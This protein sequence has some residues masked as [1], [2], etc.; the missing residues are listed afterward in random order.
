[1]TS[2]LL[3][4]VMIERWS[5]TQTRPNYDLKLLKFKPVPVTI[6]HT[7]FCNQ[8]WT[9]LWNQAPWLPSYVG[10]KTWNPCI[11]HS[12]NWLQQTMGYHKTEKC[13]CEWRRHFTVIHDENKIGSRICRASYRT[14]VVI[15]RIQKIVCKVILGPRY[16]HY[17][18]ACL[19]LSVST[20][21]ARRKHL[22]LRFALA[23]LTSTSSKK[24]P[25]LTISSETSNHLKYLFAT[26]KDILVLQ[27]FIKPPYSMTIL[28]RTN[29][30]NN[31]LNNVLYLIIKNISIWFD[32][33]HDTRN[34]VKCVSKCSFAHFPKDQLTWQIF[35]VIP[36]AVLVWSKLSWWVKGILDVLDIPTQMILVCLKSN[37]RVKLGCHSRKMVGL[38][39][40]F[41]CVNTTRR[42]RIAVSTQAL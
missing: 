42:C 40:F 18:Q 15:E 33:I 1:M 2:A 38:T 11:I 31:H 25:H 9:L 32:L 41:S 24:E 34:P 35:S 22:S 8:D 21:E 6:D 17:D 10:F 20:L 23:C 14:N 7:W 29:P 12:Q 27:F 4:L 16:T 39:W 28:R 26:L 5:L 19:L 37:H 13:S 3:S 30:V 36:S